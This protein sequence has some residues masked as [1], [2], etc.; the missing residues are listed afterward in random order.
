MYIFSK[1]ST[2]HIAVDQCRFRRSFRGGDR[3]WKRGGSSTVA[4]EAMFRGTDAHRVV[5]PRNSSIGRSFVSLRVVK[6]IPS[7]VHAVCTPKKRYPDWTC[8]CVSGFD[9]DDYGCRGPAH[10]VRHPHTGLDYKPLALPSLNPLCSPQNLVW[11]PFFF[12][13]FSPFFHNDRRGTCPRPV[14]PKAGRKRSSL[15]L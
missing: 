8:R 14:D 11:S 1:Y 4:P 7:D 10:M 6:R 15:S 9:R 3:S 2:R 5:G 13:F 12:L